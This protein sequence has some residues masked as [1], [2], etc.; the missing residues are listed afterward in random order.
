MTFLPISLALFVFLVGATPGAAGQNQSTRSSV[1][2]D[3]AESHAAYVQSAVILTVGPEGVAN[4]RVRP[5]ISGSTVGVSGAAGTFVIPVLAVEAEFVLERTISTPQHFS[6]GWSED[7]TGQSRDLLLNGNVRWCPRGTRHVEVIGGGGLAVSR[8][9]E[10]SIV[11]TD[12]YPTKI[13]SVLPDKTTTSL[14]PTVGAGVAIRFPVNRN[15]EI[16]PSFRL[17][18]VHRSADGLGSYSGVGSYAYHFGAVLRFK[19]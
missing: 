6:Y 9:A 2:A 10:R 15:L 13:T 1:S 11:R 16:G 19:L 7:Y 18:W 3:A 14:Q 8:F 4:H 12:L 5:P 17:R